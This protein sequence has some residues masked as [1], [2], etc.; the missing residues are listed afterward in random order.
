MEPEELKQILADYVATAKNPKYKG[1]FNVINSKF[2][3]FKDYDKQ[4]LADYVATATNPEYNGDFELVNSKFP[5]FFEKKKDLT[6][7]SAELSAPTGVEAQLSQEG[8][9]VPAEFYEE[10]KKKN[11]IFGGQLPE[12][13]IKDYRVEPKVDLTFTESIGNS[14]N[15][16]ANTMKS[17]IP[18]IGF[19]GDKL[20]DKTIGKELYDKLGLGW[21][22]N[23][24]GDKG[25]IS[26]EYEDFNTHRNR[27]LQEMDYLQKQIKPTTDFIE[28]VKE[29]DLPGVISSTV[30]TAI[31]IAG[32][33]IP[34]M[35]TECGTLITQT[36]A[37]TVYDYNQAKAAQKGITLKQLYEKG[38]DDIV[39]PG[40]LSTVSIALEK[41]G[42]KGLTNLI[43]RKLDAL[44]L[45]N[46][47]LNFED[48][49]T[50]YRKEFS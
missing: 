28:S 33:V 19:L 49:V 20:V 18:Q 15:N 44:G 2:P 46:F 11:S 5:E 27:L 6:Q 34:A 30:G 50:K 1:D 42:M 24:G 43:N 22:M 40:V 39:A 36:T 23:I 29:G 31:D 4:V 9:S 32:T 35:L 7:P 14:A 48:P 8:Y 13:I 25:L 41:L 16:F 21:T 3:E 37:N 26:F 45:T 47:D 17:I 38:E 10:L 12:V